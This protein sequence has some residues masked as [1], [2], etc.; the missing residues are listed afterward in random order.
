MRVAVAG[1][2]GRMGG[3][4]L[5]LACNDPQ[6]EVAGAFERAD[7]PD[8]GRLLSDLAGL[9]LDGMR[10]E[11]KTAN[12]LGACDVVIDF[13]TPQATLQH[14]RS[15][16][17][18]HR[19]M[20]IGTTGFE[21]SA[22]GELAKAARR[23]GIVKAPNMSAG[24][25]LLFSLVERAAQLLPSDCDVE[26]VEVHHRNKK[27]APSGTALELAR[28]VAR[29]RGAELSRVA[30]YGRS[31]ITGARKA[32]VIGIH[33]VRGGDVVGEHTVSF[34]A[35]GERLEFTHRA[36]SREAFA[37]GAL[38]AAKFVAA[39]KRGLFSMEDVLLEGRKP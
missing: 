18:A 25:T 32:G 36:A 38:A 19:A 3:T 24:V 35:D 22:E 15:A 12:V 10:L 9:P 27:D 30:L 37:R 2:R 21:R 14:L 11:G 29:A 16:V 23:I 1:A 7:H 33:A 5:R 8:V 34:L 31:G 17:Q 13:T 6:L 4:I 20:V 39:R 28:R 26:I